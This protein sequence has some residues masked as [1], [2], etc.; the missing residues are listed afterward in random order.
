MPWGGLGACPRGF[1]WALAAPGSRFRCRRPPALM[2]TI[3]AG[4][5]IAQWVQHRMGRLCCVF[6]YKACAHAPNTYGFTEVHVSH[7]G[8]LLSCIKTVSM[9]LSPSDLKMDLRRVHLRL[10]ARLWGDEVPLSPGLVCLP[11]R[12][13]EERAPQNR[14]GPVHPPCSTGQKQGTTLVGAPG[15]QQTQLKEMRLGYYP[16]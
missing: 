2:R 16:I 15:K 7:M 9:A 14:T 6:P 10:P 1:L 3:W 13:A 12:P 11:G 5:A 8:M 4:A